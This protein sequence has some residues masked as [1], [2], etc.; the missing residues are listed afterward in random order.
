MPVSRAFRRCLARALAVVAA[1]TVADAAATPVDPELLRAIGPRSGPRLP[2]DRL[3]EQGRRLFLNETF[4]GNGRT[5]ATCHRPDNNYT[6]DPDYIT[7]LPAD[8]PLFVAERLPALRGLDQ[9]KLLRRLALV[10]V[11][12]DGFDKPAVQRAVPHLLGLRQS[13]E[14]EPGTLTPPGR[15]ADLAAATGWSGD[16]APGDGSLRE[17]AVGAVVEHLPRT[18]RRRSGTDFRLPTADE[19]DALEAFMLSLGRRE[20]I[21]IS[22]ATGT[23][24]A[25]PLVERGRALFNSEL[26]GSCTFCHGNGGALNEGGFSGMFDIGVAQVPDSP[27]RRLDPAMPGDG[28]FGGSPQIRVAGR[29]AFGDGRFNTPSLIEAADTAPFFHDNS[30]ATI[31][32]AVRFYTTPAFAASP[33]GQVLPIVDLAEAD[34]VAI[35]ALLRSV[36]VLENI[37]NGDALL[38]QAMRQRPEVARRTIELASADTGD[39]IAVLTTEPHQLFAGSVA[40]LRQ[41][42]ALER[43]ASSRRPPPRARDALL[44]L[45]SGLKERARDLMLD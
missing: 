4:D 12:I 9:P 24:F 43:E 45:A 13:T 15:D 3:V 18:L 22:D 10:S 31:E 33:E 29:P 35:A 34:V 40:L 36:N 17:F 30:A 39:A 41:A 5:C 32:A 38:R 27:A 28:G 14:V 21:D 1:L 7:R 11:H 19:L 6:I 25:S 42:L 44:R 16:G 2:R 37:R 8:D 26:S 23:R 20:E